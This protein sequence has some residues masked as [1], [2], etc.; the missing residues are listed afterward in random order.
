MAKWE[1]LEAH[2]EWIRSK[3]NAKVMESLSPYL[4]N[5]DALSLAHID[6]SGYG[7]AGLPECPFVAIERLLVEAGEK[8]T[9]VENIKAEKESD[10]T[11]VTKHGFAGWRVDGEPGGK[12]EYVVISS[13]DEVDGWEKAAGRSGGHFGLAEASV[14]VY[15]RFL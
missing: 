2:W 12:E 9:V 14:K 5:K 11:V 10:R 4:G 1:S 7:S 8:P 15:S 6:A 3:D 13:W